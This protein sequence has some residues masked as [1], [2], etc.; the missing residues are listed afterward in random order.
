MTSNKANKWRR[1]WLA[2][3]LL[4]TM[5]YAVICLLNLALDVGRPFPGFLTYHNLIVGRLE[6]VRN[7]PAWWWGLTDAEPVITNVLLQVEDTPFINLSAP[8]NERLIYQKAWTAGQETITVIVERSGQPLPLT[9]P[10]QRFSWRHY[11]DFMFAPIVISATLCLLAA[12]FYR[13]AATHPAQRMAAAIFCLMAVQAIGV[14]PSLFHADQLLDRVLALG[15]ITTTIGGMALGVTFYQFALYF[16][17][18][19]KNRLTQT[20]HWLLVGLALTGLT[21]YI[22][23]RVMVYIVGLTPTVQWLDK[24]YFFIWIGLI[25][26]GVLAVFIR[27][28][29]NSLFPQQRR[30]QRET[31]ILLLAVLFML[32]AVWLVGHYLANNEGLLSPLRLLADSRFFPLALPLAFAA[33][34]LRYH[35]FSGA[36]NWFFLAL[37]LA[38]SGLLANIGTAVLFWNRLPLIRET[39]VPPTIILFL[40][41]VTTGLIWGWQASWQGWLG[42][43]FHW[44]R[45]NYRVVQHVGQ[46]LLTTNSFSEKEVAH[47]IVTTLHQELEVERAALWLYQDDHLQLTAQAGQWTNLAPTLPLPPYFSHQVQLWK[48]TPSVWHSCFSE[49]IPAVLPLTIKE[50]H[51]RR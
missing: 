31:Q 39:A 3:L 4:G 18:P 9:V 36:Q 34:S 29:I 51:G 26:A 49:P 11:L 50:N 32:P 17:Y 20:G 25:L 16:P 12:L 48:E 6:M 46:R 44:E 24:L 21:A 33:I 43:V 7:A 2:W 42:R 13:A 27:M 37:L 19:V 14:H 40:M 38:G 47:L 15:N 5:L 41:F 22:I 30:Q 23:T 8:L 45:I 10:L 28:V 35:T 1:D